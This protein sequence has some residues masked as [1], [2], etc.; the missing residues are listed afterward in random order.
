MLF[1]SS[2]GKKISSIR[3]PAHIT[4]LEVLEIRRDKV[5]S[6]IIVAL[7]NGEV[8]IYNEQVLVDTIKVNDVVTAIRF[9]RYSREDNT[10]AIITRSGAVTIKMLQRSAKLDAPSESQGPPK[11]QDIPLPV[12]KKTQLYIDQTQREREQVCA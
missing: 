1:V 11:E 9:G 7:A 8:R 10:L 12:P 4:N 3:M 5:F 6:A 2:A